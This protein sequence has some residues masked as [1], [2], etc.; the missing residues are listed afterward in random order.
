MVKMTNPKFD[1]GVFYT[2]TIRVN[3]STVLIYQ[4]VAQTAL[5]PGTCDGNSEIGAH[6]IGAIPVI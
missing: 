4:M 6:V 2:D 1:Q 3:M 5:R